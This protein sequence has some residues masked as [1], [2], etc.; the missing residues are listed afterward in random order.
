MT[1][2]S[3]RYLRAFTI[4]ELMVAVVILTI[5]VSISSVGYAGYR[6]KAAM[7]VDET[8]QK[9]LLAAVKLFAYDTNALPGSLSQLRSRDVERAYAQ[10]TDGK[11][12]YTFLAFL[13]EQVGLFDIAEAVPLPKEYFGAGQLTEAQRWKLLTCPVDDTP[14]SKGGHSYGLTG[15]PP[16]GPGAANK[17]LSWLLNPANA[18][19]TVIVES[20]IPNPIL[21]TDFIRRH[22]GG[23][24]F[25]QVSADGIVERKKDPPPDGGH[26]GHGGDDE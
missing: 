18:G 23:R 2:C 21:N 15:G 26:G 4:V 10:V 5:I 6:D 24:T 1:L 12:P 3:K 19:L 11:R 8:N 22:E 14:P 16:E 25:V 13:Q 17:P 7:L 20:D 9:V